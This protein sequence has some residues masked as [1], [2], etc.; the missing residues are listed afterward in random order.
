MLGPLPTNPTEPEQRAMFTNHDIDRLTE[1][2]S[3]RID[4]L[5][6]LNDGVKNSNSIALRAAED[7]HDKLEKNPLRGDKPT[8]PIVTTY[9]YPPI[10]TRFHDWHARWDWQDEESTLVGW[11]D[12]EDSAVLNLLTASVDDDEFDGEPQEEVINLAHVA[13][14]ASK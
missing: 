14:K 6:S 13:W 4:F 1:W 10:P 7:L 2:L 9:I 5:K 3:R 11:G 12:T 8:G